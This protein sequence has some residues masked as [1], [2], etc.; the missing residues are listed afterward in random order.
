MCFKLMSWVDNEHELDKAPL[1]QLTYFIA[2]FKHSTKYLKNTNRVYQMLT[3]LQS[4]NTVAEKL[5]K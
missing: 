1:G 2:W 3:Y 4:S 5:H